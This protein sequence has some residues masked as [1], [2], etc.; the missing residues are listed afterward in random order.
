MMI[1]SQERMTA[2]AALVRSSSPT[3]GPICLMYERPSADESSIGEQPVAS[4]AVFTLSADMV[5]VRTTYALP[6]PS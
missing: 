5:R 6:A 2:F 1:A 4:S 3:L